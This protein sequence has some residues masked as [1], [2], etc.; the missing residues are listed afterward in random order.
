M[1]DYFNISDKIKRSDPYSRSEYG[2]ANLKGKPTWQRTEMLIILAHPDYR[3]D[4][5]KETE[6]MKIWTRTNKRF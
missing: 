2:K 6:K 3:D 1:T 5:I 4:L